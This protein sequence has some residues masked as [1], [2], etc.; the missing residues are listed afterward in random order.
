MQVDRICGRSQLTEI[1]AR[2]ELIQKML[3][4]NKVITTFCSPVQVI[5]KKKIH[6]IITKTSL[7]IP[8]LYRASSCKLFYRM[9]NAMC[10][11][12][13]RD[14]S[15]PEIITTLLPQQFIN[16]LKRVFYFLYLEKISIASEIF[17]PPKFSRQTLVQENEIKQWSWNKRR[18]LFISERWRTTLENDWHVQYIPT[19]GLFTKLR[20]N[21]ATMS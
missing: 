12:H 19:K 6:Y 8:L 16:I 21:N 13:S 7:Q 5:N 10:L 14:T 20:K 15:A 11:L 17:K 9:A 2:N 18:N 4:Q 3:V 1:H